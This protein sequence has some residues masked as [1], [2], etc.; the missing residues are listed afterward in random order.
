MGDEQVGQSQ[1]VLQVLQQ[2]QDLRL[3]RHVERRHR[4]VAHHQLGGQRQGAGD[5]DALPLTAGELVRIAAGVLG[6]QPHALQQLRYAG[7][8]LVAPAV[9]DEGLGERV[10][11]GHARVERGERILEHDLHVAAQR[12]QRIALQGEHRCSLELHAATGGVQQAQ[13]QASGGGLATSRFAH[14]PE[15]LAALDVEAHSVDGAHV[16]DHVAEHAG[17]HREVHGEVAYPDE[18]IGTAGR[19][20]AWQSAPPVVD[21]LPDLARSAGTAPGAAPSGTGTISD[22]ASKA[23]GG[24]RLL[25][26]PD[27][28]ADS[29]RAARRRQP[30][31]GAFAPGMDRRRARSAARTHS[32]AAAGADRVPCP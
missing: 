14:Q 29:A 16:S 19:P 21:L 18:T 1:I 30:A 24:Q 4:L 6:R 32:R 9:D 5:A 25:R 15:R 31:A 7:A 13:Q 10:A 26:W 11:Y 23:V 28:A 22:I 20:Q 27:H 3:D 12:A 17:G 2:I 8:G